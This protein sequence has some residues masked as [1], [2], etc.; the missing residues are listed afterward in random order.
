[1]IKRKKW[2][3]DEIKLLKKMKSTKTN[4]E[5]S[6]LFG[7]SKHQIVSSMK[8]Y[9]IR[10]TKQEIDALWEKWAP[11]HQKLLFDPKYRKK[12]KRDE[13]C[14]QHDDEGLEITIDELWRKLNGQ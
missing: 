5:L 12:R 10:R 7:C 11:I 4:L 3:D 14:D 13:E 1:M 6:R 8:K 9:K 2:T